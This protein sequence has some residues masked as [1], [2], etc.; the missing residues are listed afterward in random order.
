MPI[1][2]YFYLF[3]LSSKMA[4]PLNYIHC[5]MQ[6][7][8][9]TYDNIIVDPMFTMSPTQSPTSNHS[10]TIAT[11]CKEY[12]IDSIDNIIQKTNIKRTYHNLQNDTIYEINERDTHTH[13]PTLNIENYIQSKT[14]LFF[15]L[16]NTIISWKTN[17]FSI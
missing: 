3:Y 6:I 16:I 11:L 13:S 12:S 8:V 2:F 7:L 9:E 4:T 5:K 10:P 14:T 1:H 15:T 17:V